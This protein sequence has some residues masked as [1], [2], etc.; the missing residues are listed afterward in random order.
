MSE[1]E[2]PMSWEL[3]RFEELQRSVMEQ[4]QRL[5]VADGTPEERRA[6]LGRFNADLQIYWQ[7][8]DAVLRFLKAGGM[9]PVSVP[10]AEVTDP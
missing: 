4:A 6:A 1:E 5:L 10:V 8:K 9:K 3:D 2:T 7:A